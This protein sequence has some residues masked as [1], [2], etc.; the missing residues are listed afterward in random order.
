MPT[1]YSGDPLVFKGGCPQDCPDTC[2]MVY[3]VDNGKLVK[4]GCGH[5]TTAFRLRI[6]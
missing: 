5:G 2:A 4:Q 1:T 6:K 3:T